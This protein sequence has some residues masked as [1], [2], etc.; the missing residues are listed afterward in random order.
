MY[1]S[2]IVFL[3]SLFLL[4]IESVSGQKLIGKADKNPVRTGEPVVI[5]YQL[6]GAIGSQFTPPDIPDG[7]FRVLSGPN[8]TMQ[9]HASGGVVSQSVSYTLVLAPLKTGTFILPAASIRIKGNTISSNP[10]QINV[11]PGS[12]GNQPQ[13]SQ[14]SVPVIPPDA[15]FDNQ[16]ED[17]SRRLKENILL[18]AETDKTAVYVGEPMVITYRLYKRE[19]I[20]PSIRMSLPT[21]DGFWTEDLPAADRGK[22]GT[23]NG[24]NY[25]VFECRKMLVIPQ[26][27]GTLYLPELGIETEVILKERALKMPTLQDILQ[28]K[29]PNIGFQNI[30]YLVKSEKVALQVKPLPEEGKP[31]SFSGLVGEYG[32]NAVIAPSTAKTGEP[33]HLKITLTGYGNLKMAQPP[34]LNL[35]DGWEAYEPDKEDHIIN[36]ED[37]TEGSITFDYTLVTS[38]VGKYTLPKIEIGFFNPE[39]QQYSVLSSA[40]FPVNILQGE[41][42]EEE[43]TKNEE[44]VSEESGFWKGLFSGFSLKS[45]LWL[46]LIPVL[47]FA[48]YFTYKKLSNRSP[49]PVA[50]KKTEIQNPP[51]SYKNHINQAEKSGGSAFYENLSLALKNFVQEKTGLSNA[52]FTR[53]DLLNHWEKIRLSPV[54][55]SPYFRIMEICNQVI[56]TPSPSGQETKTLLKEAKEWIAATEKALNEVKSLPPLPVNQEED[57]L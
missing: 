29:I 2:R 43:K 14:P 53:T 4:L 21:F 32:M 22:M 17:M 7:A 6:E 37:G 26:K 15:D 41:I 25:E 9:M 47:A 5:S 57:L 1:V 49:K 12:G 46:L 3:L 54:L 33:I 11:T 19:T 42:S 39:K 45:L 30:P 34:V 16:D 28:G 36:N 18:R 44:S 8:Q 48:G 13:L 50:E 23:L 24:K 31:A 35:P 52:A 56:Y 20:S 38:K 27:S 40:E 10:V 51:V 55:L